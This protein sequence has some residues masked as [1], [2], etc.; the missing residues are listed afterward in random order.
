MSKLFK[1]MTVLTLA[2]L[3][4]FA[5]TA[6][7]P[8]EPEDCPEGQEYNDKEV[9]VDIVIPDTTAP[10]LSG[11]TEIAFTIGDDAPDYGFGITAT[12]ETDGDLTADISVDSSAVDL[13]TEGT[14]VVTVTV[15]DAA[16][17]VATETFNVIVS[18][19]VYTPEE[20][21]AMDLEGISFDE[22][23][24]KLILPSFTA[25]GTILYWESSNQKIITNRGFIIP[26]PVGSGTQVVTL[27]LD[28]LNG[29]VR[30]TETFD[31]SVDPWG[32]VGVTSKVSVPFYGTSEEYVVEDKTDI[33]IYYVDNGTVPYIDIE[34][35]LNMLDG[36]VESAELSYLP[37]GDDE[38]EVS[39]T[40]EWEDFDGTPMTETYTAVFNFTD[41]TL[42]V[43]SY[44]FFGGY[45]AS[46]E[47]DYGEGIDYVDADY[48]DAVPVQIPLG[49][50]NVDII[51]YDDGGELQYLMPFAVTNLLFCH[52][53]YY[54]AYFNGEEIWGI[55]TFGLSGIDETDPLYDDVRETPLNSA[56]ME[57][58]LK[59]ATYN[60]LALAFDFFYGLK[61]DQGVDTYYDRLAGNA[62]AIVTGTDSNLY[63]FI[64]DWAYGLDDLHTS[65]VFEGYY[66]PDPGFEGLSINDLGPRSRSFY[67][68]GIWAM[69]DKI[70]EKYGSLEA[71]PEYELIDNDK[72]A[73]IHLDGFSIDTPDEVKAIL[74]ALPAA[75]EN[76]VFD[77]SYNTGGNVGAVFRTLGYMTDE[78][79]TY[80]EKN[81]ADGSAYTVYIESSYVAY[82]YNW[83]I[84]SS[85]VSF[86][87]ANMM[88][89]MAK[90]N[91]IATV[92]GQQSSGGAS[93]IGSI[94]SPD[95]SVL[96]VST[97]GIFSMRVGNEVD[98]YEYIST[99]Y[100]VTPDYILTD[101]TSDTQI[102]NTIAQDQAGE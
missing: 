63:A 45:V 32:E 56:D 67:E 78:Q 47:S 59:W 11:L 46:T 54:D 89:A 29:G 5:L 96:L 66:A 61:E 72:T 21:I 20:L 27:T 86:S 22:V 100:G 42:D 73:V 85:K 80:S 1:R 14:Y 91:G 31:I 102:I 82:D 48:V 4:G 8:D 25:N 64:F 98:G 13:E 50:Y 2:L 17:N 7:G 18:P 40:S 10:A 57:E 16:G 58:D 81:P 87:A 52:A 12:D 3:M 19:I 76:V 92:M 26:P 79:Y 62:E 84:I 95:G 34:T 38:L 43:E 94:I 53:L 9:C 77:L 35:F 37:V 28:A 30:V 36:A 68:D 44:D 88:I 93:S 60:F 55:D 101:V 39:Y 99:E 33:D 24:D 70:E 69:Q 49:E 41:N 65:H 97:N 74:D 6:C 15:T 71:R 90:E 51:I 83:Y 75:T 23:G